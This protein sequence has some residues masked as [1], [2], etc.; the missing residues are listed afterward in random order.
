MNVLFC[1]GCDCGVFLCMTADF[2][3]RGYSLD[4]NQGDMPTCRLYIADSILKFFEISHP[5]SKS[6]DSSMVDLFKD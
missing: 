1:I 3:S 5:A 2:L 4:F 6:A